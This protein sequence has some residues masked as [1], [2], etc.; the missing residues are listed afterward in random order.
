VPKQ[1]I[2]EFSL[3]IAGQQVQ[4]EGELL[5]SV[6]PY[7]GNV[8]AR[9]RQATIAQAD[10]A[11]DAA[12]A[13]A[14]AWGALPGIR[15]AELLQ[16]LASILD[17]RA[18]E[19]AAI[20]STDNGK[21]I[22]ETKAQMHFSARNYRFMASMADKL[23]GETKP[24]DNPALFDYTLREPLG[25]A[26]LITAWNSP[27]SLLANKLAPALA[28]G[29]TVVVKPSP[30]TTASTLKFA[31][32]TAEAGFPPGIFNVV[33][34]DQEVGE[35]LTTDSRVDRV[36]FTGSVGVGKAIAKQ[37]ADQLTPVT[38][39]LGGKSANIVFADADLTRAIPGAVSGIFAA[40][41]QTCIAGS[42]LLVHR[43]ILDEVVAGIVELAE[44][45]RCGDPLDPATDMG[46]VAHAG[47]H[48]HI[49]R[50][51]AAAESSAASKRIGGLF[52]APTVFTEV[53]PDS[54]LAQQE[55]FGP[56]LAVIPFDSDEEA[57]A[58]AN[59]TEFGLAS[60]LWTQSLSRAHTI[61][62][63][64]RAGT[65]WVNTYRTS[66]A[67]APFGGVGHSGYGRERGIEALL[68]FTRYK[69]VMIDLSDDVR[70]PFTARF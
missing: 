70:D 59:S 49:L 21:I 12:S 1:Q 8:W 22:R 24:L 30:F 25:V 65:V 27:I 64:L 17:D 42:R 55:V 62:K 48:E 51:L 41:G 6:N 52:V 63:Q 5:E 23:S 35:Y 57:V 40:S 47:Q 44:S 31:E 50:M 10:A 13:A 43:S 14:P 15:R 61:A 4:G 2:H 20:E 26:V 45:I 56:A 46:P 7:S 11:L 60:G 54:D 36:S 32:Y 19:L 28:A 66:A 38:L 29:N 37:A 58:I 69:N 53:T 9:V 39:E 16:R 33:V 68:E 18:E 34:G 67:Q 3:H